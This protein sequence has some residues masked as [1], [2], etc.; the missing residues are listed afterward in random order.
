[1]GAVAGCAGG[2]AGALACGGVVVVGAA[3][4][5]V[6]GVVVWVCREVGAEGC[7]GVV[8]EAGRAGG[9]GGTA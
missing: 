8:A 1:M 3:V 6:V 7:A 5:I 4:V 9:E 2:G